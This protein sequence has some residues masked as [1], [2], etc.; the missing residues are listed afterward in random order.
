ML[1]YHWI[2]ANSKQSHEYHLLANVKL[3]YCHVPVTSIRLFFTEFSFCL[4][5]EIN[6]SE[7]LVN[8][9]KGK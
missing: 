9:N 6:F 3:Y 1:K 2:N 5:C 8:I 4:K 7:Q